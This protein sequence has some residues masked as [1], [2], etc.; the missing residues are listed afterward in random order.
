M[1]KSFWWWQCSYRYVIYLSPPPPTPPPYPSPLLPVPNKPYGFCGRQAPC[2]LAYSICRQGSGAVSVTKDWGRGR[3]G[4]TSLIVRTV[5][6]DVK[7]QWRK[8]L[9]VVNR[10]HN[11]RSVR[12]MRWGMHHAERRPSPLRPAPSGSETESHFGHARGSARLLA[13]APS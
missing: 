2:L 9:C 10:F 8:R 6:V 12:S 5:S 1:Q 4:L 13:A 11:T 3:P 7:Q